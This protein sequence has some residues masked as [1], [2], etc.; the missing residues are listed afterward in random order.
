MLQ[1]N[2]AQGVKKHVYFI[3]NSGTQEFAR[4]DAEN[5]KAYACV[6]AAYQAAAAHT[7]AFAER[8]L[9]LGAVQAINPDGGG[10]AAITLM[11]RTLNK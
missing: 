5:G 6:K 9:A 10:S 11:G 7:A 3:R 1:A 8:M 4:P 2:A